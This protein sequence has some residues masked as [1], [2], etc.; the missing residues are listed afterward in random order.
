MENSTIKCV[1]VALGFSRATMQPI[2]RHWIDEF[3]IV[4]EDEVLV[5]YRRGGR[6]ATIS[7][8]FA[9]HPL[10]NAE[11][12]PVVPVSGFDFDRGFSRRE[13]KR[14]SPTME[15][16]LLHWTECWC[17]EGHED[18]LL[19]RMLKELRAFLLKGAAFRL[20]MVDELDEVAT[21]LQ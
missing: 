5:H 2:I 11:I 8:R 4:E 6:P 15:D 12:R 16:V 20:Q 13:Q 21:K 1:T 10:D 19:Q 9:L 7:K 18:E 17:R 3:P 14:F